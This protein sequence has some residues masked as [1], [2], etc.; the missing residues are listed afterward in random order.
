MSASRTIVKETKTFIMLKSTLGSPNGYDSKPFSKGKTYTENAE[1][2][3]ALVRDGYAEFAKGQK[4][5]TVDVEEDGGDDENPARE[6]KAEGEAP[7]KKVGG[8]GKGGK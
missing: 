4:V 2:A 8:K 5:K 7:E 6:T 1:L 3:D